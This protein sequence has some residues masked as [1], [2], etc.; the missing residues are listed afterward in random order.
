MPTPNTIIEGNGFFVS[1][2]DVDTHI[3]GGVT[4]ALV[5]GQMERFYILMGDHRKQYGPLI[6]QGFESCLAYFRENIGLSSERSDPLDD[7]PSPAAR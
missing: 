1:H 5:L 6:P 2:N 7:M 4:T 3:Y